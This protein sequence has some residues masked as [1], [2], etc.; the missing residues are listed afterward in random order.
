MFVG[1]FFGVFYPPVLGCGSVGASIP[2]LFGANR[3]RSIHDRLLQC[4][5]DEIFI[6]FST[7][8]SLLLICYFFRVICCAPYFAG[9][10]PARPFHLSTLAANC[11][12]QSLAQSI[13][14]STEKWI[15]HFLITAQMQTTSHSDG[16]KSA[17]R[18]SAWHM[19]WQL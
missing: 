11:V 7:N 8:S 3:K 16:V 12:V 18:L 5:K 1:L 2:V 4:T 9:L 19:D 6:T 15:F 17:M 10:L 14:H 13:K